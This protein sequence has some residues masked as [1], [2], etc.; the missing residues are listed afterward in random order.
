MSYSVSAIRESKIKALPLCGI[1]H[2]VSTQGS[3][4]REKGLYTHM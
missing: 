1:T 4:Q 3:S 2:A